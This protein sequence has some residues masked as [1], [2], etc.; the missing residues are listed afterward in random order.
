MAATRPARA[1]PRGR[2]SRPTLSRAMFVRG[3]TP[4]RS[5]MSGR[6]RS[7]RAGPCLRAA[8]AGPISASRVRSRPGRSPRRRRPGARRDRARLLVA[9]TAHGLRRSAGA[10]V[11]LRA[12]DPRQPEFRRDMDAV[13]AGADAVVEGVVVQPMGPMLEPA[14]FR[15]TRILKGPRQETYRIGIV[16]DCGLLMRARRGC[17]RRA[18]PAG[19]PRRARSLRSQ[20][21]REP[22]GRRG[23][24]GGR[25]EAQSG[26]R[27]PLKG[28]S[29]A[30]KRSAPAGWPTPSASRTPAPADSS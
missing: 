28:I 14:I 16:S 27:G 18:N 13:V 5:P 12:P 26:L 9:A 21:L 11:R 3:T 29:R 20:P 23:G 25:P 1:A 7:S 6:S 4:R 8:P 2:N 10:G 22:S 24:R 30:R 15:P 19:P 17:D